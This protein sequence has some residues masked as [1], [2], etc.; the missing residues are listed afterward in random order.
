MHQLSVGTVY[1]AEDGKA[2][3]RYSGNGLLEKWGLDRYNL[4]ETPSQ[5]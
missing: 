5:K 2:T 1:R 4:P 3:F